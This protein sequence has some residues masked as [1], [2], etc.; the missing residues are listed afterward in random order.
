M[1]KAKIV[2]ISGSMKFYPAILEVADKLTQEGNIVLSPFRDSRPK[3]TKADLELHAEVHRQKI[4]MADEMYVVNLGGYIGDATQ[5]EIEY[6]A[7]RGIRITYHE[8]LITKPYVVTLCGSGKFREELN[9]EF[10][11]LTEKGFIVLTPA[12]FK[13]PSAMRFTI[14]DHAV[15][16]VV[17]QKKMQMSD[18]VRIINVNGYIGSDTRKEIEWCKSHGIKITYL[19][20]PEKSKEMKKI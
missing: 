9:T 7:S 15:L 13:F 18:E 8:P 12:I 6:A 4:D 17:H 19:E 2:V 16:D 14:R 11:R 1:E 10:M 5:S 20:D 3:L